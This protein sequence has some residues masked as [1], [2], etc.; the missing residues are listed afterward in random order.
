MVLLPYCAHGA[1][2]ILYGQIQLRAGIVSFLN[3]AVFITA[4]ISIKQYFWPGDNNTLPFHYFNIVFTVLFY[5]VALPFLITNREYY[6]EYAQL[7]PLSVIQKFFV[8]LTISSIAQWFIIAGLVVNVLYI[9]RFRR[10]YYQAGIASDEPDTATDHPGE[11]GMDV[12]ADTAGPEQT[13][14]DTDPN[15]E[16]ST[17]NTSTH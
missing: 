10:D 12:P 5:A 4:V 15:S 2:L 13:S 9:R 11:S 8:S 17:S 7:V 14:T 6:E 3:L 16:N 1:Q